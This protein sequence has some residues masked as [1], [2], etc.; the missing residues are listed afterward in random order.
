[1]PVIFQSANLEEETMQRIHN[2]GFTDTIEKPIN[3]KV[4]DK[5]L[6]TNIARII[7]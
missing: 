4:M 1:M 7:N 5:V 2:M 3:I 6:K